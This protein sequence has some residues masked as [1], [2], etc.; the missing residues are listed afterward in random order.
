MTATA[1]SEW[2]AVKQHKAPQPKSRIYSTVLPG[3]WQINIAIMVLCVVATTVL[4]AGD[5]HLGF[6]RIDDPQY[7]ASNPWIQ[8][9]T[10]AHIKN[11]LTNPYYLNYSPLHL[12]SYM[13]DYAVAGLNPYAFHLSSNIWAGV[14]AGFVYLVALALTQQ[15]L[16]AV[17]AALLFVVHPVHVEAVAWISSRKDLVAAA[18]VLCC[19]LAYLKY[20]QTRARSWY[21]ISLLLFLLA[22]LGK[23]SVAAFP[24]VLLAIDL[25]IEKRP[26]SRS[27]TEKIPFFIL[28]A[29]V[30]L[31]VAH[32]QPSTGVQPD[33]GMR[34]KAFAQSMWLLTGLGNYVIYRVPPDTGGILFQLA[35]VAIL[36]GSLLLPLLLRRRYPLATTLIYWILLTYLPTQVLPFSYPVTD[37]YLFL[38]S[39][40]AVI[41]IAWLLVEATD[42]IPKGQPAVAMMLIAVI[43]F[44]WLK[45]T[46]GYLSEWQ[47][48]RSVWFG[49]T[50]KS[51]DFHVHYELG[52]EYL[53]KA[54]GFGTKR[55]NAAL[56]LGEARQYASLVWKADPRLP[57]LLAELSD[58]QHNGPAENTFKEDLQTRAAGNFDRAV[59]RKGSHIVPD[60]FLSRGVLFVDKADMQSA[61]REFLAELDEALQLP[62]PEGR[63]E[64]LITCHYNLAV[65]EDGLGHRKEA[66]SWISLAEEEQHRL[67]RTVIPELSASRKKLESMTTT[68]P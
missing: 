15:R 59:A 33:I 29:I 64:A 63:Q 34:A 67:G 35:G 62:S 49:A 39:A 7:V 43:S 6:F 17:A 52:W 65:A 31:A 5:L 22:T 50:R 53:E 3:S 11:I 28:V 18:F 19:T 58:E 46:A 12:L 1:A 2:S 14:V 32:A 42:R 20:R 56:P 61:K 38:P 36:L 44:I 54:G 25:F 23:L 45:K 21:I 37:R 55:R 27:I 48:P 66:L 24:A 51:D 60:L 10:L 41:L 40:G 4:Y 26:F 13:F 8:A 9:V 47:D 68:V 57:Q 30:A 16:T